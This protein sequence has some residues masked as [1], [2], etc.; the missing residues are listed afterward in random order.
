MTNRTLGIV[1]LAQL[2]AALLAMHCAG[3]GGGGAAVREGTAAP[4]FELRDLSGQRVSL[5]QFRGKI[6]VLDFWATWCG[7]CRMIQPLL[8]KVSREYAGEVELLAVNLREPKDLVRSYMLEQNLHA[9]VLLDQDGAVGGRYGAEAIPMQV[10]VDRQGT[11]RY[12]L[13]GFGPGADSRL[14]DEIRKLL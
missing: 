8:E 12:V 11:V 3:P 7:P 14:R 9:T 13:T 2:L 10:L 1:F 6:V 5:E 4:P